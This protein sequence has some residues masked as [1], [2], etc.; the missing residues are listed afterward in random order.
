MYQ[1]SEPLSCKILY[2]KSQVPEFPPKVES[3]F[4]RSLQEKKSQESATHPIWR[5]IQ[6]DQHDNLWMSMVQPTIFMRPNWQGYDELG[7]VGIR[8]TRDS[9]Q[10]EILWKMMGLD[11]LNKI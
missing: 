10:L 8:K 5:E 1:L 4:L 6:Q 7:E 11:E 2:V 9:S 3:L